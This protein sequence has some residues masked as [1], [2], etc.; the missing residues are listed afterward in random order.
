MVAFGSDN[1]GTSPAENKDGSPVP[2]EEV[3]DFA[4]AQGGSEIDGGT[5]RA[6]EPSLTQYAKEGN[7]EPL[8]TE[9]RLASQAGLPQGAGQGVVCREPIA[10]S[11]LVNDTRN[12][13]SLVP[14]ANLVINDARRSESVAVRVNQGAPSST[15]IEFPLNV[16]DIGSPPPP[17]I[18]I[19]FPLPDADTQCH[20]PKNKPKP[21][22]LTVADCL[23]EFRITRSRSP[24]PIPPSPPQGTPSSR[25]P[26]HGNS[27]G[28]S[29]PPAMK[30]VHLSPNAAAATTGGTMTEGPKMYLDAILSKLTP[31]EQARYLRAKAEVKF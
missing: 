30:L 17:T 15:A 1:A 9:V 6:E 29:S 21:C 25:P 3:S 2:A 13:Q 20:T 7:A 8:E 23:A 14:E 27:R 26:R 5:E 24:S 10:E 4:G 12:S 22:Q 19:D 11:N 16:A 28:T 31:L 18:A